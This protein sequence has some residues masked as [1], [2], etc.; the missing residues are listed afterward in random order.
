MNEGVKIGAGTGRLASQTIMS[1]DQ[2]GRI[3]LYDRKYSEEEIE[4]VL[5]CIK[6]ILI[7]KTNMLFN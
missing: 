2:E 7:H 3:E 6:E 5:A 1:I 4:R